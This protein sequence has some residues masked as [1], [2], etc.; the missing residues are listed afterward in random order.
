MLPEGF[1]QAPEFAD[2]FAAQHIGR[3]ARAYRRHPFQVGVYGPGGVSQEL[4]GQ[5]VGLTQAQISRT[6]SGPPVRN[7]DT[8]AH[9][10]RTLGIPAGYLWFKLPDQASPAAAPVSR[11]TEADTTA[12]AAFRAADLQVGGG[13]LY[14]SVVSYLQ[15]DVGS[16]LFGSQDAGNGA[17]V[18]A[19][20][21]ALT[22]MAGWMAHDGGRDVVAGSHFRRSLALAEAAADRRLSAHV[23][24]SMS[25]LASHLGRCDEAVGL[26]RR[27]QGILRAGS[28]TGQDKARVLALE[29]RGH[30]GIGR[31]TEC[32]TSLLLAEKAMGQ[33]TADRTSPW[34]SDFDEA[35]LAS[36]A[37]RCLR[38]IGDLAEARRQAEHIISVRPSYRARSRALAQLTLAAALVRQG[39]HDEAC[40]TAAGVLTMIRPLSSY[41]VIRQLLELRQLLE[42]HR[43]SALVSGL[44]GQLDESVRAHESRLE[45]A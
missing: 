38:Q 33:A 45:P 12:L 13:Q 10:A 7:L 16:R 15:D 32:T 1:W 9:W 4:L 39:R 28:G 27:A 18:F 14:A 42:P 20:G 30:A 3:V 35:S 25:H 23:L 43:A 11:V 22:E 6:E 41:Q 36:E 26:A 34:I 29:A 40:G 8:L 37:A 17:G 31:K 44:L 5:W 24:G 19:A 2:A 21:A